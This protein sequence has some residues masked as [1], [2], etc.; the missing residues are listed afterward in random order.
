VAIKL[1]R[2]S[3]L[4][5]TLPGSIGQFRV[6]TA[7]TGSGASESVFYLSTHI[8]FDS[9]HASN[10]AMLQTLQ[11][12]RELF[13]TQTLPF[14]VLM[15]RDIDD[16]R[17]STELIPYLLDS[18]AHGTVKLFP[19]IVAVVLPVTS[20]ANAPDRR[21]PAVS[22]T[23]EPSIEYEGQTRRIRSGAVGEE[24]FQFEFPVS[25][26]AEHRHDYA[27]L[28]LNRNRIR[29]VII[30]GQH[31][32]MALL[33]L[34]RNRSDG[35]SHERGSAFKPY[36]GKWTKE[37]INGFDLKNLQL[38]I[39]IC[40]FPGLDENVQCE[41]DVIKA[42][43]MLFLT[44]NKTARKVSNSRN[45]LLDDRDLISCFLRDALGV[46]KD[47]TDQSQ[48]AMRIWNV[49][50]DQYRDRV[51]IASPIA[52]TGV[53][54]I[55]YIIEHLMF[56]EDDVT[57]IRAR[58]GKFYKRAHLEQS[59]LRRLNGE[60]LLGADAARSLRRD[61]FSEH[62]ARALAAEFRARYGEALLAFFDDFEPIAD[63][64]NA[65]RW[66][67]ARV[68]AH[69]NALI[70][71]I[72][73]EGQNVG[74][75]FEDYLA[76]LE[77]EA[78]MTPRLAPGTQVVL[79]QVRTTKEQTEAACDELNEKRAELYYSDY[80]E[81][82]KLR[83]DDG[84]LGD[85]PKKICQ[86]LYS[87][88]FFTVAFQAACVC[89]FFLIVEKAEKRVLANGEEPI[90]RSA[91]WGEYM[92][93]VNGFFRPRS[94]SR[95]RGLVGAMFY[96]VKGSRP[97]EWEQVQSASTFGKV[98]SR[99]EMKPDDWPKYRYLLLEIWNSQIP[100]IAAVRNDELETC[101]REVVRSLH[102]QYL[103]RICEDLGKTVKDLSAGERG[104]V[105]DGA[106]E[107]FDG[108]LRNL[109][110]PD[111]SRPDK[112]AFARLLSERGS[113][114]IDDEELSAE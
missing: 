58:S 4:D 100:A 84:S 109:A 71:T 96:A 94:P 78:R 2:S 29:L 43:R 93:C 30:D 61:A 15:Q 90:D 112:E 6:A 5:L 102:D 44:L 95:L 98:V 73:F 81:K 33:A 25:G 63:H 56:D 114:P 89:G 9:Q 23:T 21:Y 31:R 70:R 110:L 80:S 47:R 10:E 49:E 48:N 69:A 16:A 57:G 53:S 8:S 60:D 79:E 85:Q 46:I 26:G 62:A 65:T 35:W 75:S 32:A 50:L 113:E 111:G 54:H 66:L 17:V 67:L 59:L 97:A 88:V 99:N 13:D 45:I 14:D 103:D 24:A 91:A 105:F 107:A 12:F 7:G 77:Q 68:S 19:P 34:H 22:D 108:F 37:L 42:A 86:L 64:N 1:T 72:L 20:G 38:P 92:R 104:G 74:R 76:A 36:Y 51:K 83:S 106:F 3:A 18:H 27:R 55:H 28:K 82:A 39:V 52:C 41:M 101:R 87:N 40:A 11:P